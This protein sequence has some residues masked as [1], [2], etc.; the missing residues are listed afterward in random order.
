MDHIHKYVPRTG[1]DKLLPIPSVGDLLTVKREL[2]AQDDMRNATT[3]GKRKEGLIPR[4][5]D[6]IAL[7]TF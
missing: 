2:N 6:L 1:T 5:A 4:M 7:G 3:R